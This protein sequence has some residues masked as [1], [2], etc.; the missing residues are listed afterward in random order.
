VSAPKLAAETP[1]FLPYGRQSIDESD[2]AAVAAA[3]R[4][5]FLTTGP[6]VAAFEAAFAE[7][8]DAP[9]AVSCANGTAALHLAMLALGIGPGDCVIVPSLTFLATANAVRFCGADVVFA[10]VDPDTAL[11]TPATLEEAFTR[12]AGRRV[13]AVTP[14]H[15]AGGVCDI[16]ALA[17]IAARRGAVIV[18][19]A[20][21]ALGGV[22]P[23]GTIGD[24]RASALAAFSFHPVKTIATGEGGMVTTRDPGIAARL[25]RLRA[26]GM[27]RDEAE[28]IDPDVSADA[29]GAPAPWAYEMQTLG[30]NYRL[31]DLQAALGLSQLRKLPAFKARRVALD[32]AYRRA[33]AGLA[34]LIVPMSMSAGACPHLFVALIDFAALGV[35][36]G[37]VMRRLRTEGIGSQVHYIPVHRQ[38][39]YRTL[40]GALALGGAERFY[41]RCLSLPLHA[42]MDE[43]DVA[44]VVQALRLS[45]D[46]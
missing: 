20:C 16:P 3:L 31:C 9:F 22:A 12:A 6:A 2:I 25:A 28:F 37:D 32:A 26:H 42:G 43:R 44:R 46:L 7:S 15:F 8:V 11:L 35:T 36:R 21:H 23:H 41:A 1:A 40:Y 18:E 17:A 5:D 38:P 19:D 24:A 39:Y 34:P 29:D 27:V 10:D 4:S 33:L 14:V 13:R 45:L 30:Y